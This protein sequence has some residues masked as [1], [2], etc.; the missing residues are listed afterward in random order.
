MRLVRAP[1][2]SLLAVVGAPVRSLRAAVVGPVVRSLAR[3][4]APRQ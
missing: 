3:Q 2:R 1:V 4:L